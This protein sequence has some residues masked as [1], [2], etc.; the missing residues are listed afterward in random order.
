MHV[1]AS[2][3]LNRYG[4]FGRQTTLSEAV[5]KFQRFAGLRVSG[6]VDKMTQKLMNTPRCGLKDEIAE[7]NTN[8]NLF[9]EFNTNKRKWR[10]RVLTYRIKTYPTNGLR[11]EDVDSETA[12]AFAMWQRVA[13]IK[14]VK[15]TSGGADIEIAF[16]RGQHDDRN[17]NNPFDGP[18]AVVAHAYFPGVEKYL[19]GDAHFD[20]DEPWSI[21]CN[22][23]CENRIQLLNT[24]SL[25][26]AW[27]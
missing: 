27:A 23:G 8:T 10:K 15:K 21:T 5:K 12:K 18:G 20:D 1:D 25:G 26:T 11:R 16:A 7:F 9:A 4:Y 24:L 3:Y 6:R 19:S 14:F 22:Q 17:E 2:E 13:N